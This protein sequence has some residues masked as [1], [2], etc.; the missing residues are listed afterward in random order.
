MPVLRLTLEERVR[1]AMLAHLLNFQPGF[2]QAGVSRYIEHLLA[3]LPAAAPEDEIVVFAGRETSERADAL[4]PALR[5]SV[6]RLPTTR[7]EIRILWEQLA[8]PPRL[9]RER[10]DLVH[11]PVNVAPL[12]AARSTVVTV[13]DLAFL[14]YPEQYPGAKQRYLRWMT[15]RTVE[16]AARVI[17]V[18]EHTRRDIL[19][20]YHVAPERVVVVPNGVGPEFRPAG[21]SDETQALRAAH[22]LPPEFVLFVGTLQPRKNLIGLLRAWARV[23]SDA[24]LVIVGAPGWQYQPIFDEVRALGIGER[25]IFTGYAGDLAPWYRAAT[26]FVYPSLYEGFGLPVIEAMACGTPVVTSNLSALPEVAGDA[27]LTV[28]PEDR[29]AL[30]GAIAR[31]LGD[32]ELRASLRERGLARA[33][34]FSWERTARE[35]AAVYHAAAGVRQAALAH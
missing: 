19:S 27:A 34:H 33:G 30:A 24:P 9:A 3:A 1:I 13:H 15:R 29:D 35:T 25:V 10:I 31:L 18:S 23:E 8:A 5:W 16:H 20:S 6:S 14:R 22:G 7:P 32:A 11:A 21:D 17:A 26:V 4:D 2:R 28:D 12:L